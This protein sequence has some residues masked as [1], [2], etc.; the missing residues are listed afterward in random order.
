M[1]VAQG[2]SEEA[3]ACQIELGLGA[4]N[5]ARTVHMGQASERDD[6]DRDG[7]QRSTDGSRMEE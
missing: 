3:E 5:G 1:V 2:A 7:A 6:H 4:G